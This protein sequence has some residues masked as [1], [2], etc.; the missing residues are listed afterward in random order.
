V[1]RI[2]LPLDFWRAWAAREEPGEEL[3][4]EVK[5][6]AKLLKNDIEGEEEE[7]RPSLTGGRR[8]EVEMDSEGR[9]SKLRRWRW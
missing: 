2:A 5:R 7:I 8:K 3:E 4:E 6:E 1:D 9:E